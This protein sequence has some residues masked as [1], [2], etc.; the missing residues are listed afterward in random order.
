LTRVA[1]LRRA[2]RPEAVNL[3]R[4]T[5]LTGKAMGNYIVT[6]SYQSLIIYKG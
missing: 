3:T 4:H 6:A 5:G 2:Q 1:L